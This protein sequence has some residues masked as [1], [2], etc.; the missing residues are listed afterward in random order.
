MFCVGLVYFLGCVLCIGV[1]YICKY[2]FV[3]CQFCI[4]LVYRY[5]CRVFIFCIGVIY[6]CSMYA[7]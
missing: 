6:F 1:I 4:G 5:V 7:F 2:L 3:G